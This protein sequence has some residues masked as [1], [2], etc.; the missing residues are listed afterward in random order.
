M[1]TVN[2]SHGL[3]TLFWIFNITRMNSLSTVKAEYTRSLI[4][5]L[6]AAISNLKQKNTTVFVIIKNISVEYMTNNTLKSNL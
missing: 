6:D 5:K 3:F 2:V 1:F 4:H